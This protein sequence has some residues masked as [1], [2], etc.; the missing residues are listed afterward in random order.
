MSYLDRVFEN[1]AETIRIPNPMVFTGKGYLYLGASANVYG[2]GYALTSSLTKAVGIYADDAGT[3][4][5]A[6]AVRAGVFR[7]LVTISHSNE[8]SIFG[9]QGQLKIKAPLDCV[10]TTGNRAGSWNYLEIGGTLTKTVTLSGT[11]KAT[12]GSFA[13]VDWDGVGALTISSGHVLAGY[14][15]LTN[16]TKTGGAFTQTGKFAAFATLNNASASY[17]AFGAGVHFGPN[18]VVVP[19]SFTDESDVASVTNGAILADI[20]GTANAGYVKVLVG[21]AERYIPLYALKSS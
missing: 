20:H 18:S 7:N 17:T 13:M 10:L 19:F 8:T 6:G 9:V 16:I 21:T 14:A 1:A 5:G 3:L 4:Y 2:S 11:N 12:A 15:A